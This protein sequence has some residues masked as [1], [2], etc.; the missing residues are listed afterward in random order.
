MQHVLPVGV[1]S[2]GVD[3]PDLMGDRPRAGEL[4]TRCGDVVPLGARL[5]VS[6]GATG[7]LCDGTRRVGESSLP[8][9]FLDPRGTRLEG[10]SASGFFLGLTSR[11]F[12]GSSSGFLLVV[13]EVIGA[14]FVVS[15]LF[16]EGS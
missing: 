11:L 2:R 4:G 7:S 14:F 16:L 12:F 3:T 10:S 9:A 5:L 1:T 13:L 8:G 15:G 6:L